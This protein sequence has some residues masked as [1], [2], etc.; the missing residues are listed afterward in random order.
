VPGVRIDHA[1]VARPSLEDLFEVPR[2]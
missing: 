2:G 1:E